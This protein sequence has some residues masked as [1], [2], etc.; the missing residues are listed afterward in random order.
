MQGSS[1]TGRGPLATPEPLKLM[2]STANTMLWYTPLTDTAETVH[3]GGLHYGVFPGEYDSEGK[4][5]T[6]SFLAPGNVTRE[7]NLNSRDTHDAVRLG[8]RIYVTDTERGNVLQLSYPSLQ[9]VRHSKIF[10]LKNHMNTLAPMTKNAMYVILHNYGVISR[11]SKIFEL[12]N[13]KNAFAPITKND[14]YVI[15]HNYGVSELALLNTSGETTPITE[16]SRIRGFGKNVHGLV[17]WN[18]YFLVLDSADGALVMVNPETGCWQVL[19]KDPRGKRFYKGLAVVDD[20]AYFGITVYANRQARRDTSA[21]SELAAYSL[22]GDKI[23]WIRT[24][25]TSGL[26]NVVSAPHLG[27]DSTYRAQYTTPQTGDK[28]ERYEVANSARIDVA[29]DVDNKKMKAAVEE[30]EAQGFPHS[31]G[32]LWTSGC[33]FLDLTKKASD[34]PSTAGVLLPLR[35]VDMAPLQRKL[36]SMPQVEMALL[37]QKIHT[38]PQ[39]ST[40]SSEKDSVWQSSTHGLGQV[41]SSDRKRPQVV[42]LIKRRPDKALSQYMPMYNRM[43]DELGAIIKSV[44]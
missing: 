33:P 26:L 36:R 41:S 19:Y 9:T 35:E 27:E 22:A 11:N 7:H 3:D 30:L 28:S 44:S 34:E 13:H 6:T 43:K 8:D 29:I 20:V 14:I 40:S 25:P 16:V 24:V 31:T 39:I 12:Q 17:K 5:K 42:S 1:S 2:L 32:G 15:L 23:L 37:Q 4:L 21:S 10:E 38:M 18:K